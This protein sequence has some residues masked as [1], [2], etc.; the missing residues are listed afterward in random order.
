[1]KTYICLLLLVSI[2]CLSSCHS[3]KQSANDNESVNV[4]VDTIEIK[5]IENVEEYAVDDLYVDEGAI[6]PEIIPLPTMMPADIPAHFENL[7][8]KGLAAPYHRDLMG[9]E[10]EQ[11][12]M[13]LR[14][15]QR[16]ATGKRKYYPAEDVQTVISH[17]SQYAHYASGHSDDHTELRMVNNYRNHFIAIAAMLSTNMDFLQPIKDA[18]ATIG[19]RQFYDWSHS[20]TIQSYV[21]FPN[22]KNLFAE[23]MD[24]LN[25][26]MATKIFRLLD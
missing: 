20:Y 5:P 9:N 14:E 8:A 24:E 16:Y 18:D 23:S 25:A 15:L 7:E 2:C 1:M 10:D 22:G 26:V 13:T 19:L 17:L 6:Y 4:Q 12:Q 3:K 21:F 11:I